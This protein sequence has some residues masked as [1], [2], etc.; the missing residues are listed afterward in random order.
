MA[1][2]ANPSPPRIQP[3]LFHC[4][5]MRTL[6]PHTTCAK[7]IPIPPVL[8]THTPHLPHAAP[9]PSHVLC[10]TSLSPPKKHSSASLPSHCSPASPIHTF[11][12]PL[13]HGFPLYTDIHSLTYMVPCCPGICQSLPT[14]PYP[15]PYTCTPDTR[16]HSP[17]SSLYTY[18]PDPTQHSTCVSPTS[19]KAPHLSLHVHTS[20]PS[21]PLPP[22]T[23]IPSPEHSSPSNSVSSSHLSVPMQV[24][25]LPPDTPLGPHALQLHLFTPYTPPAAGVNTSRPPA[26]YTQPK[27]CTPQLQC[28]PLCP[29]HSGPYVHIPTCSGLPPQHS[30]QGINPDPEMS[31]DNPAAAPHPLMHTPHPAGGLATSPLPVHPSPRLRTLQPQQQGQQSHL[32]LLYTCTLV[33]HTL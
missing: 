32:P 19:T 21:K 4:I 1:V 9:S 18:I 26:P 20:K 33:A 22:Y 12:A 25:S 23:Y 27:L 2:V 3:N 17:K 24:T 16:Y 28:F 30:H 14:T 6:A 13:C 5:H 7:I 8:H 15:P 31:H 29:H 10:T 11:P